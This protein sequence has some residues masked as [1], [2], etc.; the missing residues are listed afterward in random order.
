MAYIVKANVT[1]RQEGGWDRRISNDLQEYVARNLPFSGRQTED[2]KNTIQADQTL[3]DSLKREYCTEIN[4]ERDL[5][6]A[7]R[8]DR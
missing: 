4:R 3:R 1:R 5:I 7:R 8:G 6:L 2:M